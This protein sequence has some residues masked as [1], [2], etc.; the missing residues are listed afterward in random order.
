MSGVERKADYKKRYSGTL[1][2]PKTKFDIRANAETREILFRK[3][4]TEDLYKWQV[5]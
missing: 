1:Q 2:L 5:S 3:R 4:S